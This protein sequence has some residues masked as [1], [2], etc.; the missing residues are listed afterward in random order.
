MI[1]KLEIIIMAIKISLNSTKN[2]ILKKK[3]EINLLKIIKARS[4]GFKFGNKI[5]DS[6]FLI[7]SIFKIKRI[8][9]TNKPSWLKIR[10]HK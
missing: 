2:M 5:S 4:N 10:N 9:Q 6:L 7:I 1:K 3:I 8:K